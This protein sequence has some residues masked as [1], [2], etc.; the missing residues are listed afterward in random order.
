MHLWQ[1]DVN[2]AKF[3]IYNKSS[4]KMYKKDNDTTLKKQTL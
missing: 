4:Y 2:F 3:I 1:F